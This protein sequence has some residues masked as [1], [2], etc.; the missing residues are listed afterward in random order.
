MTTW[1]QNP[2]PPGFYPGHEDQQG[3]DGCQP[4][5]HTQPH[6][7]TGQNQ[8][9]FH[10]YIPSPE[11]VAQPPTASQDEQVPLGTTNQE[12]KF[13]TSYVQDDPV[14]GRVENFEFSDKSIRRGFIRKVYAILMVQLL[15]T[16]T[17]IAWFTYHE[18]TKHYVQ[19]Y[20]GIFWGALSVSVVC[21]FTM[22]CFV[23]VRRKAPM[24]FI[25]LFLFTLA[26]GVMLGVAASTFDTDAVLMAVGL[27]AAVCFGLTIFA[28]Q[29]KWDFTVMGG[30][31]FVAL[32]I[33][34]IFGIVAIFIPGKIMNLIYA[35]CG[36][37][38]FSLYLIYDTQLMIG[39]EHKYSISPEEYIF[40]ALSLYLDIVNIFLYIL[41][42]I[43]ASRE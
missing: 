24:N 8:G 21:F 12:T 9:C 26:E 10:P 7:P 25:F 3:Y 6:Y 23:D 32:I 36:A 11:I 35:S 34:I 15:I 38:L 16:V 41:R 14:T 42:I 30:G 5:C 20:M 40:A 39:G 13:G 33:L 19:Q 29:T 28:M 27:C 2:P 22:I 1:Q 18:P 4:G 37:L 17:F 43:G 31:L